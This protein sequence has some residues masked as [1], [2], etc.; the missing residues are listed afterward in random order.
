MASCPSCKSPVCHR[1]HREK[2][3]R[4]FKDNLLRTTLFRTFRK[5]RVPEKEGSNDLRKMI[6]HVVLT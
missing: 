5:I 6:W 3:V 1:V 2:R 4:D